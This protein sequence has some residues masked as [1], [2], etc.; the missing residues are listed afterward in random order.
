MLVRLWE[1]MTLKNTWCSKGP[2]SPTQ[3]AAALRRLYGSTHLCVSPGT[4]GESQHVAGTV[5]LF[6]FCFI[7]QRTSPIAPA[8]HLDDEVVDLGITTSTA[9]VS[10]STA[11]EVKEIENRP[12]GPT[13]HFGAAWSST[14]MP[15]ATWSPQLPGSGAML[16]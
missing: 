8:K 14:C 3:Q 6:L 13:K 2:P 15:S 9:V 16:A 5:Y 1:A 10:C 4:A 12:D 7:D 11:L